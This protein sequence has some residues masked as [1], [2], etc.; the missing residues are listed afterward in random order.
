M[1]TAI[2]KRTRVPTSSEFSKFLRGMR[3]DME[4]LMRRYASGSLSPREWADA[5]QRILVEGHTESWMMGRQRGGD[6]RDLLEIDFEN[7]LARTDSQAEY[8]LRFMQ[9][10]E[11][12]KY[13]SADGK[14]EVAK[15]RGRLNHW[16]HAMR[17]TATESFF[18]TGS[19]TEDYNW[20]LGGNEAHCSDCPRYA[21]LNPYTK[22][23][24]MA[25]PGSMDTPCFGYCK[26]RLVRLSDG[27]DSFHPVD[28][29]K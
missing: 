10:L 21:A 8:L 13:L 25:W 1:L 23:T 28:L 27:R 20:M 2:L 11:E 26:C 18:E 17:G 7:G 16:A 29:N 6:S 19:D 15:T 4:R 24:M 3:G 14:F 5:M 12:G 9:Q 22:D